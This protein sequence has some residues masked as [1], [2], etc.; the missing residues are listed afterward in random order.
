MSYKPGTDDHKFSQEEKEIIRNTDKDAWFSRHPQAK[1]TSLLHPFFQAFRE[2]T[3][4]STKV[5]VLGHCFGGKYALRL[6]RTNRIT[7]AIAMH[8]VR[9]PT[10]GPGFLAQQHKSPAPLL[11]IF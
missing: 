10:L 1:I 8:P 3:G 7:S 2:A 4:L 6:A 5:H 11:Q 9:F